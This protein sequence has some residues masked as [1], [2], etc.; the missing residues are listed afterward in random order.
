MSNVIRE[1]EKCARIAR[2][3]ADELP[4]E[5]FEKYWPGGMSDAAHAEFLNRADQ[6]EAAI[7]RLST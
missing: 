6:Y 1:L 7:K 3:A 2:H 5:L 4:A